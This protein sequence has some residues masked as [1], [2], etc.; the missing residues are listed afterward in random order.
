MA[1]FQPNYDRQMVKKVLNR[2]EPIYAFRDYKIGVFLKLA[3]RM[4]EEHG[5]DIDTVT[6]QFAFDE[7]G[8]DVITFAERMET[9]A[10][11]LS[12]IAAEELRV[13]K[14]A[15]NARK[16]K[17]NQERIDRNTL[18]SLIDRRGKEWVENGGHPKYDDPPR[19]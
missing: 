6:F 17:E 13:F 7:D 9:D 4:V 10:E 12:R 16:S 3:N 19:E 2:R 15:E 8:A 18:Q 5:V 1:K 14:D 11:R